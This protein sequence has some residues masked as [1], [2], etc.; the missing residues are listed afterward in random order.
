MEWYQMST[1]QA[2][3]AFTSTEKGLTEEEAAR[4]LTEYGPNKLAEGEELSRL[5]ILLHQFTS[6]LIYILLI[7][8]VVTFLL[9]EYIDTGVI[10]AVVV[11]NAIIGYFQ[12]FKAEESVRSLKQLLVA[13]ARVI[14]AGHEKEIPGVDLVPGDIVLLA[15][16]TRVPVDL[17]L[18]HT[19]ELRIDEAMLTGESLPVEKGSDAL[20]EEGLTPADQLNMAFT[21]TAV[22]NGRGKGVVTATAEKTLLGTIA[23]EVRDIGLVKAPIQEKIEAFSKVVGLIVLGTAIALFLLG[24]LMGNSIKEMFLTAVAAAVGAI[25]E[26]LPIVVTITLAAGVARMARKNAIVRKLPAVETLG[27]T[28]VICSDKTGTLTR[29]EMTVTRLLAGEQIYSVSGSGYE[30]VGEIL[31]V[32]EDFAAFGEPLTVLLRIG[33]LCNESDIYEEEDRF[34][35]DGDP[36]EGALIVAA[37]KGGL[38][39]AGEKES[40]R[41]LALVPFE[42]ER[43]WMA[44]LHQAD[45]EK[46]IL[47]KGAPERVVEMCAVNQEESDEVLRTATAF[48]GEGMR[49]LA[50]AWKEAP[51]EM[52]DLTHSDA[53]SGLTLAGLQGMIDPPRSEAIEAISGCKQAGIRVVMITG[54]HA[55]TAQ[56]IAVELGIIDEGGGVLVGRELEGMD[57]D[58]LFARVRKVSV[59]A[60]VAPVHKLRITRQLIRHGEVVAMT[61][62]GV[63]DAPALKAAHIGIA[64]GI[65][66]TDVAKEAADMVLTDDNFTSIFSAVREGR[67]VFDNLRKVVFFLIPTGVADIL[68]IAASVAL[69]LPLPFIPAQILWINLVTN[70]MQDVALAFEPAEKG[71]LNRPPRNPQEGIMSRLLIER[72]ILVGLVITTGVILTF[73]AALKGGASLEHARTLTVTT[74]VIFQFFQAWNCRSETESIFRINAMSNP[75]LFYS[76]IAAALA[77]LA[78]IYAPSLQWIFRTV[79]LT[80]AEW[81]RIIAVSST[82]LI[83]V[84]VDKWLRRRNKGQQNNP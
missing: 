76:M 25:P 32:G 59:Y 17:R 74:M 79:P 41:Q 29:N 70:G 71:V 26:G 21:G 22:V 43:G 23:S 20:A 66:G 14:R 28:T 69:G 50:F 56:A 77:Q 80:G 64:M 34:K 48:A 30:P 65:T 83:A 15:S 33:L 39:R 55:V 5:T 72:T 42:S 12:E 53:E 19:I 6:P 67:I 52:D 18:L 61:G 31:P 1:Q 13:K 68:S 75:I 4:R 3:D 45:G 27:S 24:L 40:H 78:F 16:G 46:L 7:A 57:D 8:A 47:V 36:T 2:L 49:V 35:V 63:N 73:M 11:L 62:D 58:E 60:R 82:V 37:L 44:T 84:E 9:G 81:L 38:N 54:D 51:A 10:L